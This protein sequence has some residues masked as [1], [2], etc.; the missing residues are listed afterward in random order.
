PLH[1]GD[2]EQRGAEGA[3]LAVG[4]VDDSARA[5][6]EHEADGEDAVHHAGDGAEH[7]HRPTEVQSEDR[8]RAGPPA[9]VFAAPSRKT[10]RSRSGRAASSSARPS[11]R[12]SPFSMK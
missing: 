6:H 9:K 5:V 1:D 7:D 3:D 2:A 8:H 12:I 11:K 10:D 4:E